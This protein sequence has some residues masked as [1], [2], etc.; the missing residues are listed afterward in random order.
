MNVDEMENLLDDLGI[1]YV[2][3]RGEEVQGFCPGHLARTG[4]EDRNPSWFINSETG[5]HICFSCQFNGS[6]PY[7]VAFTQNLRMEDGMY[8]LDAAKDWVQRGGELLDA[9]ER[10]T[11]PKEIFEMSRVDLYRA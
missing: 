4:K 9:F 2:G 1:E 5:A 3:S 6:L 7:L 10:A 11:K 8:D